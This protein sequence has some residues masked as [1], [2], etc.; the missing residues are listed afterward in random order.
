MKT[1]FVV[2]LALLA[3]A[4]A[5]DVPVTRNCAKLNP[6][7]GFADNYYENMAHAIHSMNV[8][9]LQRFNPRAT[10]KNSV[11]TVNLNV[12]AP[13]KVRSVKAHL[14]EQENEFF[15]LILVAAQCEH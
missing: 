5:I 15:S 2:V 1:I 13:N 14:H 7:A 11:P 8:P 6:A 10:V 12:S 9:G 4:S 3:A